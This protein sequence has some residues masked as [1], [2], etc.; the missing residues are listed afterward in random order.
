MFNPPPQ[1]RFSHCWLQADISHAWRG[2]VSAEEFYSEQG[3]GVQ[4]VQTVSLWPGIW[5]GPNVHWPS[6]PKNG[7]KKLRTRSLQ[8]DQKTS[9]WFLFSFYEPLN[10]RDVTSMSLFSHESA[11]E[12]SLPQEATWPLLRHPASNGSHVCVC[13]WDIFL[14]LKYNL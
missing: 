7:F 1:E 2:E 6:F 8:R 4:R 13:V 12:T 10:I 11:Y 14:R 5:I 3:D 9:S